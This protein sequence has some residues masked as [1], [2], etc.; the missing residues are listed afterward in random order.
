MSSYKEVYRCKDCGKIFDT[1]NAGL[2]NAVEICPKC[3]ARLG[4]ISP[5]SSA[6]APLTGGDGFIMSSHCERVIARKRLFRWQV[7]PTDQAETDEENDREEGYT[8]G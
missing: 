6:L 7:R 3:G 4:R 1:V 8:D 2:L 5:M